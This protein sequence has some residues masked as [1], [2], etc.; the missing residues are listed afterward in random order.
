MAVP[1]LMLLGAAAL[2]VSAQQ[3]EARPNCA[4]A[5]RYFLSALYDGRPCDSSTACTAS[6]TLFNCSGIQLTGIPCV[7][8]LDTTD[9]FE[10]LI[11][12]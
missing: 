12:E 11:F 8:P 1:L 2:A 6:G 7:V 3:G 10:L 4:L 5:E 9:L